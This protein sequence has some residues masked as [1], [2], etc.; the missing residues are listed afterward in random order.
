MNTTP[1]ITGQDVGVATETMTRRE[2]QDLAKLVRQRARL[3]RAGAAQRKAELMADVERQLAAIYSYDEDDT[4]KAATEA[5]E[6]EVKAAKA[7]IA[8]RCKEL[9]IPKKFAP[10]LS[11]YW[12]GRGENAV[13]ARRTELRKVAKT[14]L[15]AMEK[16]AQTEI[17]RASVE[18]QTQLISDGLTS[19][20]A[21]GFLESLPSVESLMPELDATA[22]LGSGR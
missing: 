1:E 2:R 3:E 8:A 13:A 15:D 22:L 17:E 10:G 16:T 14:R 20:A 21:R 9:G 12:Y 19:D 7:K 4:W 11:V 18:A 5:A 6:Q